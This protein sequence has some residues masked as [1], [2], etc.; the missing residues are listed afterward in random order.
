MEE[1]RAEEA[2]TDEEESSS[3]KQKRIEMFC[4]HCSEWVSKLT[5][6]RH[7]RDYGTTES[8]DE[9]DHSLEKESEP[10][11]SVTAVEEQFE[12]DDGGQTVESK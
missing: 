4:N 5:Y 11:V 1:F 12:N 10:E 9:S 6:Y 3:H 2:S 7:R 8:V